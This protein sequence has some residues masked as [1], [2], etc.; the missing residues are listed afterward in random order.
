MNWD[1]VI[2]TV[3]W[4]RTLTTVVLVATLV[5]ARFLI[6]RQVGGSSKIPQET[7][8]RWIVRTRA[9]LFFAIVAAVI[10]IWGT[11]LR[12]LFVSF[13]AIAV[14][15]VIAGKELIL[16][17]S[18]A[19][20]RTASQSFSVGDKIDVKGIRGYVI[21]HNLLTTTM[22]EIGPG[23]NGQMQTGNLVCLP[24]SVFLGE[25][26]VNETFME[27]YIL[28]VFTVPMNLTEN[29]EPGQRERLLQIRPARS[30]GQDVQRRGEASRGET[31]AGPR[32]RPSGHRAPG[33]AAAPGG[34]ARRPERP[35]PGEGGTTG[36][37]RATDPEPVPGRVRELRGSGQPRGRR[38]GDRL[39]SPG[40][41]RGVGEV[42]TEA[43]GGTHRDQG[44]VMDWLFVFVSRL[45]SLYDYPL[46]ITAAVFLGALLFALESGFWLGRWWQARTPHFD[47]KGG[48][49]IALSAMY[50]LLGL[51]LA[52]T[53]AFALSRADHRKEGLLLETNAIGTAFLRASLL[54][55]PLDTELQSALRDYAA[56]RLVDQSNAGT[57]ALARQRIAESL[58]AQ[59]RLWP[60]AERMF[61]GELPAPLAVSVMGSINDVIDAHSVRIAA[62]FDRLPGEVL[63]ML[64][65]VASTSLAVSGYARGLVG[66]MNRARMTALALVLA[67]V[68]TVITDFDRGLDGFIRLSQSP[69]QALVHEMDAKLAGEPRPD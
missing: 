33:D 40:S 27:D 15:I 35:D 60:V 48:G 66:S 67:A 26:V 29:W 57:P 50:G 68:M 1:Q 62:S 59:S 18:G 69:M 9:A 41:P 11:E 32:S 65:F 42:L 25:A 55:E 10:L 31:R 24:N 8:R 34:R 38:A 51:V 17:L 56:T 49:D 22:L 2:N 36:T 37:C 52:F 63:I 7:R 21:D 30:V 61:G 43:R 58:K 28:Y 4:G 44:A 13:F 3:D 45:P 19:T 64:L 47:R 5:V 39:E 23:K 16:C 20:L 54:P 53:Y 6:I 12:A 46:W 14:A